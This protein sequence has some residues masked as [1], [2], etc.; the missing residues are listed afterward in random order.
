MNDYSSTKCIMQY[1][2]FTL[3]IILLICYFF[4]IIL[5][6]RWIELANNHVTFTLCLIVKFHLITGM[7]FVY[8]TSLHGQVRNRVT[9]RYI[10]LI[11]FVCQS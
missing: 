6:S 1:R 2:L 7:Y 5:L 8:N 10:H 9:I 11:S 3:I 4:I